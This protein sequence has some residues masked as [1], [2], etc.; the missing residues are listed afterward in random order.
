MVGNPANIGHNAKLQAFK[1]A[2]RRAATFASARSRCLLQDYRAAF[3]TFD[4]KTI[5]P[6][7]LHPKTTP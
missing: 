2:A 5:W 3:E 6:K 7:Q 1:V 4:E